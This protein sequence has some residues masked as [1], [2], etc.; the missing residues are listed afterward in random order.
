MWLATG[1]GAGYLP[2]MPGTY[3]SAEGVV[4]YLGLA[5]VFRGMTHGLWI[6]CATILVLTGL[7]LWIIS[8]ALPHFS[9]DDPS[10][11]VL[12]EVAGQAITLLGIA[13]VHTDLSS[14][15]LAPA[16][17][18]LM[19][20][21]LDALKPYPIWKLGHRKGAMGVLAD[22]VGAAIVAAGALYGLGRFGW[23]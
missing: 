1:F 22:D 11:I 18:F 5:S 6:L 13:F 3:G 2:V 19:F 8:R 16:A 9:N 7:S 12:D 15:W 21:A 14:S 17:G 10:A 23:V 4:L 20:R